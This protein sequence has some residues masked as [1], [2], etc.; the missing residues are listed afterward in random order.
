MVYV[1]VLKSCFGFGYTPFLKKEFANRENPFIFQ[2]LKYRLTF[3]VSA[4]QFWYCG[5]DTQ[6]SIITLQER[7]QLPKAEGVYLQAECYSEEFPLWLWNLLPLVVSQEVCLLYKVLYVRVNTQC[8]GTQEVP[9]VCLLLTCSTM[10]LVWMLRSWIWQRGERTLLCILD[11]IF[12]PH[13]HL[14]TGIAF[15]QP[16][17]S[18]IK[19]LI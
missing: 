7:A 2:C 14:C 15:W 12:S 18:W 1:V 19:L 17:V 9:C 4:L 10:S 11:N 16:M 6:H 8:I 13:L 3:G 5:W